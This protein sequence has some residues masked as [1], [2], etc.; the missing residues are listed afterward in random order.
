MTKLGSSSVSYSLECQSCSQEWL[1]TA[2][3]AVQNCPGCGAPVEN[4]N[5]RFR[6]S[7][8]VPAQEPPRRPSGVW[9]WAEA[10]MTKR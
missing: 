2:D 9:G 6:P 4:T 7:M 8:V 3:T 5:A 10:V 1:E